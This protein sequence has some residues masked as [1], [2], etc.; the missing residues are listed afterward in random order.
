M[1]INWEEI[2]HSLAIALKRVEE[3][4]FRIKNWNMAYEAMKRYEHAARITKNHETKEY[5]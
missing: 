1:N 3:E 5:E 4:P 2:A